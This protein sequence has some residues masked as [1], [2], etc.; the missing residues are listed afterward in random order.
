VKICIIGQ[1]T[2][3]EDPGGASRH[4]SG[5]TQELRA[6]GHEVHLLTA[7]RFLPTDGSLARGH[8]GRLLRVAA[9]IAVVTPLSMLFVLRHRPDVVNIHFPLDGLGAVAGAALSRRPLVVTFHGPWALEAAAAADVPSGRLIT[10]ARRAIERLVYARAVAHTVMSRAFGD[11]LVREYDVDARRVTVIAPGID[12]ARFPLVDRHEARDRLGLPD[13]PTI[14]TVRRLIPRVGLDLA[15][16]ALACMPEASRPL[17]VIGGTGP[18]RQS[19]EDLA[20][21]TGVKTR[22]RFLGFVPDDQLVHLYAAGDACVVPSR[23]LEGFGY[24]ALE[25]LAAGTPVVAVSTDGLVELVGGIEPRWLVAPDP[26]EIAATLELVVGTPDDFPSRAACRVYAAE[27][28]W[29]RIAARTAA[30]F[31]KAAGSSE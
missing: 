13:G 23:E 17:L 28:A 2:F 15:I 8:L 29:P 21:R 22:V 5:L 26:G 14:V 30:V 18:E 6:A 19:L 25:A 9:R 16:R 12:L 1:A 3:D 31:A 4:L 7:A 27:F 11:L 20:L 24:G 10:A